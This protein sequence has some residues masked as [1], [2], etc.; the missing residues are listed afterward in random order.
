MNDLQQNAKQTARRADDSTWFDG[1]V[2]AG[3]VA[4]G[5]VYVVIA[6]LAVQ[7]A[8]GD[9]EGE[10]STSGAVREL[11]QQPF[12]KVLVWLV[13]IGMFVLVLWRALEAAAGHRDEEGAT[14]LRKRLTSAGK[15]VLYAAIGISA[16]RVATGSG[17]GGGK[18]SSEDT[19]TA[20]LLDLPFGQ[21]LVFLVGLAIIGYG[22]GLGVRAWTEKFREQL[23]AEGR[24]G[25]TGTA[26]LWLGK[27]GHA[28]KGVALVIVG[29]LFCY[30]A[31]THDAKKSGGL[32]QALKEVLDQPFGP[33]LLT[34][35]GLGIGCY[36]LFTFARARHLSR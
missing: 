31:V 13:A 23:S 34:V 24:S 30:A 7:L 15:G 11:A 29:A 36:G 20:K 25:D 21:V 35:V 3:L 19:L 1:A 5:L 6:W 8:L 22:V 10:A 28:A 16:L 9:R 32:D 17:G 4:Y 27:I 18:R 12:G 14:R 33:V 2:R 26:Y